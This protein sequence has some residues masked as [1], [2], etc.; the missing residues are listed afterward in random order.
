MKSEYSGSE[1]YKLP[2]SRR[3]IIRLVCYTG[4]LVLLIEIGRII[5]GIWIAKPV[6]AQWG[7]IEKGCWVEALFLRE[8]VILNSKSEGNITRKTENGSRIAKGAVIASINTRFGMAVEPGDVALRLERRLLFLRSE[9]EALAFE[10]KRVN[11]E[12]AYRRN[13]IKSSLK[14]SEIKEDLESLEQEKRQILR[15]TKSVRDKIL[16]TQVAIKNELNGFQSVVAPEAGYLFF[17]YDNWEGQLRS[18]DFFGLSED[19]FKTNYALKS[20][21]A[22]VKKGSFLAKIISPFNQMIAIL[23]DTSITGTPKLGDS[24]WFKI[25]DAQH[26]VVIKNIIPLANRKMILAFDDPGISQQHMPNRRGKIFTIYR[27]THGITVPTQALYKNGRQTFAKLQKGDGY[28]LQEV[29]V[30]ETDSDKAVIEGIN[31]GTTI[32]SR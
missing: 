16:R 12:I 3:N 15:N 20:T 5:L 6:V 10:L 26:S 17:H 30:L 1:R 14:I 24:W 23:I 32:L 28:S 18:D 13:V 9:D 11:N 25:N 21:G 4:L 7:R 19:E 8:E 27:K 22:R 29:Q 2:R 31:F